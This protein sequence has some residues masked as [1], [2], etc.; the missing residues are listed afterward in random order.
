MEEVNRIIQYFSYN[1]KVTLSFFFISLAVL[2]INYLTHGAAN[3]YVFSTERA[4]LLNPMT[5]LRFFTHI[6]GHKD[7][8]HFVGNFMKILLVGPLL[9]EKY[10]SLVFLIMILTTA[11]ITAIV[12]FIIGKN[13]SYGASGIAFMMIVCA[14][15]AN[16]SNNKIPLTLVLIIL[17]YLIDEIKGLFK[18]D[19]INHTSHIVGA[20]TGFFYGY[21][22][23]NSFIMEKITGF[24][25]FIVSHLR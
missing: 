18:K 11:L 22:Y 9:E 4:S 3:R 7:W 17:F 2:A 16:L 25:T 23:I 10:G 21:V 14:A 8:D 13:R 19:T 6:L 20:A 5:Y 24:L 1:S 15:L 12:N